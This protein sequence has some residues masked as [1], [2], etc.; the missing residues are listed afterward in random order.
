MN[1]NYNKLNNN[2]YFTRI[3][4]LRVLF[5]WNITRNLH[6]NKTKNNTNVNE[7]AYIGNRVEKE[8]L[9]IE[10]CRRLMTHFIWTEIPEFPAVENDVMI[11]E[12]IYRIDCL[13]LSAVRLR[14]FILVY[15]YI[16]VAETETNF[17]LST[18]K[19]RLYL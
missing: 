10:C 15:T 4:R 9:K 11:G 12:V 6:W 1:N 14:M 5:Q 17:S 2:L 8:L 13:P 19:G 18:S 7:P 3:S 16:E